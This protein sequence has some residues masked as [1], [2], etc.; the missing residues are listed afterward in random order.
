MCV[1]LVVLL[2]ARVRGKPE[3]GGGAPASAADDDF[4]DFDPRGTAK[5]TPAAAPGK[6]PYPFITAIQASLGF[7]LKPLLLPATTFLYTIP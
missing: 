5:P 6:V 1:C 3:R 4:D 7:S 2:V